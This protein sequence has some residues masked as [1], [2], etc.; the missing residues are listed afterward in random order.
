MFPKFSLS[1]RYQEIYLGVGFGLTLISSCREAASPEGFAPYKKKYLRK[2]RKRE[3]LAQITERIRIYDTFF[4]SS[5]IPV[6][7]PGILKEPS[8]AVSPYIPCS[9]MPTSWPKCAPASLWR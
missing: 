2:M 9:W 6:R 1:E 3:T 8:T 4:S 7:S 5:A